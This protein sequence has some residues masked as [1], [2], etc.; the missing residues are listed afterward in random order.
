MFHVPSDA[1]RDQS[2]NFSANNEHP[3]LNLIQTKHPSAIPP[4]PENSSSS[5]LGSVSSTIS[6][7]S[8]W[9]GAS[10][11]LQ[12]STFALP[13]PVCRNFGAITTNS[14]DERSDHCV[15]MNT[16]DP[17]TSR[18]PT[19]PSL[20]ESEP[21]D[22][23][24]STGV[25]CHMMDVFRANPFAPISQ[26]RT[27]ST[28]PPSLENSTDAD[29]LDYSDNAKPA[30]KR[31]HSPVGAEQKKKYRTKRA[32]I[33]SPPVLPFPATGPQ[34]MF[35]YEFRLD[36][37]YGN[38]NFFLTQ[39]YRRGG[40]PS[41]SH[42]WS[43]SIDGRDRLLAPRPVMAYRS[44]DTCMR[45]PI[46]NG[47]LSPRLA[48]PYP[49]TASI[50]QKAGSE[51]RMQTY[52][53]RF[54]P[55]TPLSTHVSSR[56]IATS[57]SATYAPRLG[58]DGMWS[59]L[60][61]HERNPPAAAVPMQVVPERP[62]VSRLYATPAAASMQKPLYACPLCPR[63]FQL[64]NGLA[65]H[66]KWHDRV[67]SSIKNPAP[68]PCQSQPLRCQTPPRLPNMESG[69]VDAYRLDL[70]QLPSQHNSQGDTSSG[71]P[72]SY[73]AQQGTDPVPTESV[74]RSLEYTAR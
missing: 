62:Q 23:R 59:R 63:D 21:D 26:S 74:S 15:Q 57:N 36:I 48:Y 38:T 64:P 32:R 14:I 3:S 56:P 42:S 65:L 20:D 46:S 58:A 54:L 29:S 72:S 33:Q 60:E 34:E 45:L 11:Q 13:D 39:D 16:L 41:P 12:T 44:E 53:H 17:L 47:N 71:F 43:G 51:H 25:P 10:E 69:M 18:E 37:P 67:G 49:H 22:L 19:L 40:D 52:Y 50:L 9:R 70:V 27:T 24:W 28:T 35:A 31:P 73:S 2:F 4:S 1:N 61:G 5:S 66:L 55:S 30:A 68:A 7:V 6:S 8:A